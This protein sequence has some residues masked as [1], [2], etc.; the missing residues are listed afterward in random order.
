MA[1]S[2][3][4]VK[5][6][7]IERGWRVEGWSPPPLP[8]HV[9]VVGRSCTLEPLDANT[10]GRG[11]WDAFSVDRAG[12]TWDFLPGGPYA[13]EDAFLGGLQSL[14]LRSDARLFAIRMHAATNG[15]SVL[16]GYLSFL[17][18]APAAGSIEV[19]HVTFAPALQKTTAATE[20]I[21]LCAR[22]VF[23]LGYRRFEWKCNALNRRSRCAAERF[24]FS[25][26]GVFRQA[27]VVKGRNRDTAWFAMVDGE[28]AAIDAAYAQWLAPANFTSS[29]EQRVSLSAFT[30]PLLVARDPTL[31]A[32]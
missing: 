10:H 13:T 2:S 4:A 14:L 20:A 5:N 8:P 16:G 11:L 9:P 29:G 17:R 21:I 15:P 26:E 19:G 28:F 30:A 22:T 31:N 1:S 6:D 12:A 7:V 18:M 24:G 3:S 25:Y 27:D 32:S 23:G